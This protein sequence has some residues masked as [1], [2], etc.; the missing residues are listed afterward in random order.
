[1]GKAELA[2]ESLVLAWHESEAKAAHTAALEVLEVVQ[3]V[4]NDGL[5]DDVAC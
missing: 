4:L 3:E 1:V 5:G 2:A